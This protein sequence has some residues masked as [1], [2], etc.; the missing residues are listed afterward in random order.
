MYSFQQLLF[1]MFDMDF[2]VAGQCFGFCVATGTWLLTVTY[3]RT[4]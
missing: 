2:V 4:G 3:T 1:G